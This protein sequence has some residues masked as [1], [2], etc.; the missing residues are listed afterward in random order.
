MLPTFEDYQAKYE[1]S[2]LLERLS[3][4]LNDLRRGVHGFVS[5]VDVAYQKPDV[6]IKMIQLSVAIFSCFPSLSF[7]VEAP[8][9]FCKE[10][11]NFSNFI[12][13]L[14]SVDGM[15]NFQ[16]YWKKIIL[17]IAG[18][19][20]FI[21]SSLTLIDRF[22]L[23]NISTIKGH[24]AAIPLLGV[25]PYGGLLP[26]SVIGLMSIVVLLSLDTRKKI[27]KEIDRLKNEKLVFWQQP[28][29]INKVQERQV[30]YETRVIKLKK[31]IAACTDLVKE[32][33][34]VEA[35]LSLDL[36]QVLKI[37]AC[38]KALQELTSIQTNQQTVLDKYERKYSQW[39]ALEREWDYIDLKEVENFRQ[40][41][42]SKWL[43]KLD[44]IGSEQMIN[45]LSIASS[46]G[47]MSRQLFVIGTVIS[48]YG[49]IAIP[50]LA[51]A[52][53]EV[54]ISGGG[55]VNF[56]MKRSIQKM[57]TPSVDFAQFLKI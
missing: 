33:E 14:K 31:E 20:L 50:L 18:M 47:V 28:L 25:L 36:T 15:L 48:G 1:T 8:K 5:F 40:A 56:F 57:T 38:Q 7:A 23:L 42:E 27:A 22:R 41:K 34:R 30:K 54:V 12:K 19:T 21:L 11:R 55:I 32:G 49:V 6:M 39:N 43:A 44:K 26:L 46:V 52:G 29:I 10:A 24:L 3:H 17:N 45:L 4:Q 9:Q 13:G 16:F 53:I 35:E 37:K 51:N 2:F